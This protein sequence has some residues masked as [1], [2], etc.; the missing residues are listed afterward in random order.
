MQGGLVERVEGV[1]GVERTGGEVS[2]SHKQ[3]S[4]Q[5]TVVTQRSRRALGRLWRLAGGETK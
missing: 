3:G 2:R 5:R 4:G 1:E